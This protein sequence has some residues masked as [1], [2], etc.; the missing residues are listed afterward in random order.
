MRSKAGP[1]SKELK[2]TAE[3][4]KFIS[5]DDVAIVGKLTRNI[6][7]MLEKR[8]MYALKQI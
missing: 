1:S 7:G 3:V 4:D 6:G 2:S 5:G 8:H